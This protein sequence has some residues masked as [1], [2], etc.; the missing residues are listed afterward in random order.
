[1][2]GKVKTVDKEPGKKISAKYIGKNK[3]WK[4]VKREMEEKRVTQAD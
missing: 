3:F 2:S 4:E 1:M